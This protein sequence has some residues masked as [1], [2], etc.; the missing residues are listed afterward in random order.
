M[1][2]ARVSAALMS[3]IGAGTHRVASRRHARVQRPR[4]PLVEVPSMV[5]LATWPATDIIS[6]HRHAADSLRRP[7]E[8]TGCSCPR[9]NERQGPATRSAKCS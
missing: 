6:G 9:E 7:F 3:P 2:R 4:D 8:L 5:G 1:L